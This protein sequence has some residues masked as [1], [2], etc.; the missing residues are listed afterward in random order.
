MTPPTTGSETP[1]SEGVVAD[2]PDDD[3]L[4]ALAKAVAHPARV[5]ILRFLAEQ[6][7]CITGDIVVELDLAQS[8]VSQHLKVLSDAGLVSVDVQ[9]TRHVYGLNAAGIAALRD[10][11]DT[12]W[13]DA[14]GAFAAHVR[15]KE[16][17]K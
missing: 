8:T 15:K 14:L 13:N 12:L 2:T 9:G 1:G 6:R 10:Y 5:R 17:S 7:A 4:A 11:L 3:A 16:E